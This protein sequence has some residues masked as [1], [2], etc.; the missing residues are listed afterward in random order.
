M[1]RTSSLTGDGLLNQILDRFESP[2]ERKQDITIRINY[3]KVGDPA[4]QDD[5]HRTL[6][7]AER[8]GSISLEKGSEWRFT[9]EYARVRLRDAD[10]LYEFLNRRPSA[11]M[12]TDARLDLEREIGVVAK[13]AVFAELLCE[14]NAAWK[15]NRKFLGYGPEEAD[16]LATIFRLAHAISHL[17]GQYIDHRTFSRRV[18]RD[19]K[20]LERNETRIAE[21]LKRIRPDLA[22]KEPRKVLR[23]FGI[24]RRAHPLFLK[25]PVSLET[26]LMTLHGTG[27]SFVGLPWQS[28][29]DTKLSR[30]VDYVITIENPTSFWRYCEE[31]DGNYLALLTAGFPAHDVLAGMVHLV[32]EARALSNTT[33]FHWGDIDAGGVRIA[34]HLEDAFGV[35]LHLHA[36]DPELALK[37]GTPVLS[38]TG[39][40]KLS[41]RTGDIS[42]LAQWLNRDDAL[43]LEQEELDPTPPFI[44]DNSNSEDP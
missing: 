28:I 20:T 3:K 43:T 23:A 5:F 25:G 19:S 27:P 39:L 42:R 7:D 35:D 40:A 34:A 9:Q 26:D 22:D 37:F 12:A 44:N 24:I 1:P 15:T 4:A 29:Q 36:M 18:V 30:P 38:R 21:I 33:V 8:G 11:A 6:H 14:A 16:L 10:R 17:H 13:E 41:R 32:T 31:V 2:L